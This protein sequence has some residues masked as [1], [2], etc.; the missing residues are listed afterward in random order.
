VNRPTNKV[1]RKLASKTDPKVCLLVPED[2]HSDLIV[3]AE[4]NA[5]TKAEEIIARLVATL[6]Q[7]DEFM[8]KDRLIRLITSKKL[9]YRGKSDKK[10]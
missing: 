8:A 3:W 9:A 4:K 1:Y 10:T 7:N 5:R 6:Q 2:V